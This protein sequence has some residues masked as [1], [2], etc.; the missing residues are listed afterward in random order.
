M[1]K[2]NLIF[3][4][5]KLFSQ[6]RYWFF[7][8]LFL[9]PVWIFFIAP[10][11]LKIPKDFFYRADVI[12]VDNFYDEKWGYYKWEQYSNTQFFYE[13]VNKNWSILTIKNTF[14]VATP[15]GKTIFK[16]EPL[17]GI[18]QFTWKHVTWY[19]DRDRDWYLFAPRWLSEKEE[20]P[21]WHVS[22]NKTIT[23]RF[24]G[25][26]QLYGIRLL[27]YESEY[28]G[29]I[30][31]TEFMGHLPG[32]PEERGVK[33]GNIITLW[34]EPISGY[35][36]KI[37][38]RS[39]E[40]FYFD[41]K[42]GKKIVPY[43]QFLNTYTEQS[44]R[45]HAKNA[46]Q[47]RNK[48][49]IVEIV[50][51][52]LLVLA[53]I[54]ALIFYRFPDLFIFS[55][56]YSIPGL[57]FF[58]GIGITFLVFIYSQNNI[59]ENEKNTFSRDAHEI[60]DHIREKMNIYTNV[61]SWWRWFFDASTSV[62]RH[63]WRSYVESLNIQQSYPGIQGVGFSRVIQPAEKN[64]F[65]TSVRSEWFRD[66]KITPEGDRD[67]YT[68]I[69]F[70]EPFDE[71]NQRAFWYDMFSD[72]VRRK[73]MIRARDTG[74]PT[75]SGKVI[76]K[77]ETDTEIQNG[78]LLYVP[79]YKSTSN[80]IPDTLAET[81][82][83][84][85]YAPFR[86]NDFISSIIDSSEYSLSFQIFDGLR[87]DEKNKIY[88]S[89][90]FPDESKE[91]I[92]RDL[93]TLYIAGHPWTIEFVNSPKFER[94]LIYVRLSY[95]IFML[96]F[97]ISALW[98]FIL[99]SLMTSREKA[100]DYAWKVNRKLIKNIH[101]LELNRDATFQA[102]QNV[103]IQKDKYQKANTR[104]KIATRSAKIGVWEWDIIKNNLIWDTQ[105][106]ALYGYKKEEFPGK[107]YD[108]WYSSI[109]PEDKEK[110][111]KALEHSLRTKQIF[112]MKFRII[113]PDN[114]LHDIRAFWLVQADTEDKPIHMVWVNWDITHEALV[115]RQKTEFVSIASHQ[116]RTPLTAVSWYTE[117]MLKGDWGKLSPSQKKYLTEIYQSNQVM[118]DLVGKLLN[119]SRI[120]LGTLKIESKETDI[121]GIAQDV[122]TEQQKNIR[123]KKILVTTHFKP[124]PSHMSDPTLVRMIIQNLLANALKYTPQSGKI[125]ISL[126]LKKG[127]LS[128][129]ITD[130]GCGI[131]LSAQKQ[132]FHK[133]F[134]A[135]NALEKN[136][137]GL[138]LYI[139]KSV[140]EK[141]HGTIS[142]TSICS[143][144]KKGKQTPGTTFLVTLPFINKK[145]S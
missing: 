50:V 142:F 75:L 81:I 14:H 8:V 78:F 16:T 91:L 74:L 141:L 73:A 95:A 61:L 119:V 25:D 120:D 2:K 124:I 96:G 84:Y 86:M 55:S 140:V 26:R 113:W 129:K 80:N 27:K 32:V 97:L 79:V 71:K 6:K 36:V 41:I 46:L 69:L 143:E 123:T 44:V 92:F 132:I 24:V 22:N 136:G 64:A 67:V 66:F 40:Y 117:M 52:G 134:R 70:L 85:V 13:V 5:L 107:A 19:G 99:H 110:V 108:V 106:Y 101:E 28:S 88:T 93:V 122:I 38:D 83:W 58:A 21:Y 104:L 10:F 137:T 54:V 139:V 20:F 115:E 114:S 65:V 57:V 87:V 105:M 135:D 39:E 118:I 51:P 62:E 12:S 109:H 102:L 48:I 49:I 90:L 130:T 45:E 72:E 103:E 133:F 144:E 29:P 138:G 53:F 30:D 116:L 121:V 33:L 131:P 4:F 63:E 3:R 7:L 18:S 100:V 17:Y 112:D 128:I 43:N 11:L 82:F 127:T 77:Q 1:N 94:N 59:R 98:F 126:E 145:S 9:I 34:I 89:P 125:D 37:E 15:E 60:T 111:D 68:S 56:K 35:V 42:T 23:M 47:A 31:Q 76:L